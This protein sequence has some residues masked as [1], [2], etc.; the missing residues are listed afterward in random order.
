MSSQMLLIAAFAAVALFTSGCELKID[1]QPGATKSAQNEDV[2][3]EGNA[4]GFESEGT[5]SVEEE[6]AEDLEEEGL[7]EEGE[8]NEEEV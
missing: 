1:D 2:Q 5:E 6:G 8:E 7:E 3:G 4:G